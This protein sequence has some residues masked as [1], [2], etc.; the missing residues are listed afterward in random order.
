MPSPLAN[1]VA[2]LARDVRCLLAELGP[3]RAPPASG[4]ADQAPVEAQKPQEPPAV[5]RVDPIPCKPLEVREARSRTRDLKINLVQAFENTDHE[6]TPRRAASC[7]RCRPAG[8]AEVE[9]EDQEK[10]KLEPRPEDA[11]EKKE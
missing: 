4:P 10:E 2:G 8:G 3:R 6:R 9:M 7:G 11:T 5:T 1:R